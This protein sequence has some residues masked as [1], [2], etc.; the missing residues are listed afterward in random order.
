MI[1]MKFGGTS[2]G[3]GEMILKTAN[4]VKKEKREKVVVVSAMSGVQTSWRRLQ[5][6]YPTCR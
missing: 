2:V 1:V 3:S 6:N 4:L 5:R